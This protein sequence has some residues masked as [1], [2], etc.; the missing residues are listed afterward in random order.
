MVQ[1]IT[2]DTEDRLAIA[3]SAPNFIPGQFIASPAMADDMLK[4][5]I[6]ISQNVSV[7]VPLQNPHQLH[8]I[9]Q[10]V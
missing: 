5:I 4:N 1:Y 8:M 7:N 2:G 3:V 10:I 6:A 9:S